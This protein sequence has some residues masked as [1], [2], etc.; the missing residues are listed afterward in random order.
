MLLGDRALLQSAFSRRL[1]LLG[2]LAC[3]AAL[4]S[5]GCLS[6]AASRPGTG[7]SADRPN[8]IF[9]L[10]DDLDLASAQKMPKV[11]SLLVERGATFEEAFVSYPACCPSRA[12]MLTG[13]YAHNH[14]V[15]GNKRPVG[16]FEKFRDEGR[17][18]GTIAARL[19]ENGYRTALFGKYLNHYPERDDPTYVSPG[20]D[21]WYAKLGP[22]EYYDYRL[23]ENGEVVS[24]GSEEEDY[25]TDVLSGHATD[26]V[27]RAAED[28]PFF[29]YVAPI[30]PHNPATPAER[31]KG[32]SPTRRCPALRPLERGTRRTSP[33]GFRTSNPLRRKKVRGSTAIIKSAWNQCWR[34]TRWSPRLSRSWKPQ[35]SWRTPTSSSPPT[36]A[37]T[38][39]STV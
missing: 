7:E 34:S 10:A 29:A 24:Y 27:R 31:H 19:Q 17:E 9:V 36:T 25:L 16:G 35:A 6:T 39:A 23:N 14:G 8:I 38:W 30:A 22:H 12:T 15:R 18:E 4:L 1:A 5:A 26:F 2:I 3:L 32:A 20:W 37:T 33:P 28:D 11:N 13:L 21:E